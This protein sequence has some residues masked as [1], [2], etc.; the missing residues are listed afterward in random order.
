M[1]RL[2]IATATG[3]NRSTSAPV[4]LAATLPVPADFAPAA[5][6]ARIELYVRWMA[7]SP[8][9]QALHGV[10]QDV[11]RHRLLPHLR[12]RH[13]ARALAGEVCAA[14]NSAQ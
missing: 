7:G 3:S 6:W 12:Y 14:P 11:G 4:R 5:G 13:R 2:T 9:V 8:A 1:I 10:A